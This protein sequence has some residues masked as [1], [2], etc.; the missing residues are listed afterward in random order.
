LPPRHET[1]AAIMT[2]RR[3]A[4]ED[5]ELL[6]RRA[7]A[8]ARSPVRARTEVMT[9]SV[10]FELGGEQYAIDARVVLQ[11]IVLRELT[12]LPGARP[13][14]FGLTHWRGDVLTILDLRE[15]LGVRPRGVT[16]LSRVVVVDG[17][18]A[19]FGILADAAREFV[20]IADSAIHQLPAEERVRRS[21]VRGI[22]K[23]AVLVMDT[24]SLI[25]R[26]GSG[27]TNEDPTGMRRSR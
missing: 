21:L 9:P 7:V 22:T 4:T 3:P 8:L 10:I 6:R 2:E 12:R 11:I 23:D 20:D 13:P 14:L 25:G 5:T 26:Y 24:D 1:G 17:T 27:R 19:P 16:D 15:L 18:V